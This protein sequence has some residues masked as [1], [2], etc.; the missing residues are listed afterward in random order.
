MKRIIF[1]LILSFSFL[2]CNS[3]AGKMVIV[4]YP[5]NVY[6]DKFIEDADK[7]GIDA[8]KHI[9]SL[10]A[11]V[12][13]PNIK[14]HQLGGVFVFEGKVAIG[15]NEG[16]Q[17]DTLVMKATIYH[18]LGHWVLKKGH[19]QDKND[20]MCSPAPQSF[21]MWADNRKWNDAVKKLFLE[22]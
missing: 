5:Y 3:Q 11:I 12:T 6:V 20:I 16:I 9:D 4:E 1:I 13:K 10:Y 14:K 22:N 8:R 7:Y 2:S 15:L 18:E 17:L 21:Y 19:S